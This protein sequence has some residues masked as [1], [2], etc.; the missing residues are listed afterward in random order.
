VR[1]RYQ[2]LTLVLAAGCLGSGGCARL[3]TAMTAP[4]QAAMSTAGQVANKVTGPTQNELAGMNREVDRLLEG[5]AQNR[6]ELQRIKQELDRLNP[7]NRPREGSAQDDPERL[8]PWHPRAPKPDP[9]VKQVVRN[10]AMVLGAGVGERGLPASGALPD[11]VPQ[12][13]LRG[14]IDLSRIRL[15]ER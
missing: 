8:R 3:L 13:E 4:Q 6:E 11:G 2:A 10:D 12:A 15:R 1:L 14:P 9:K 7:A 5:R